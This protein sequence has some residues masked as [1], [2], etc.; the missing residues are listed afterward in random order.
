V[1]IQPTIPPPAA[2][3]RPVRTKRRT[4]ALALIVATASLAISLLLLLLADVAVHLLAAPRSGVN[5]WGY[6]GDAV[7]GKEHGERRIVA[8]GGS[9]TF[10]YGVRSGEAYPALLERSLRRMARPGARATVVNLGMNSQGAYGFRFTLEDYQY[11]DYDLVV[12][13]EGYNDLGSSNRYVA[14]RES[15]IFRLV[16]Y[17]PL[18]P[19]VVQERA[20][21]LRAAGS[22][23]AAYEGRTV[24][25]PGL[26][27][28]GA[29]AVLETG[30]AVSN[31]LNDQLARFASMPQTGAGAG[32][33]AG[34]PCGPRWAFYC[35]SVHEAV[36]W[37]LAHGKK[38]LVA[39]QP[40]LRDE[41][42]QQQAELR[43][44]LSEFAGNPNVA[45]A[46]L[47]TAIDVSN[48]AI[49]YDGMHLTGE[50]N[51]VIAERMAAHV[52]ALLP[53]A[54]AAPESLDPGEGAR[55]TVP[56]PPPSSRP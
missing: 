25:Q 41:H 42:R 38:V 54:F 23:D 7:G 26:A 46:D 53:D 34:H 40:Y 50:G 32:P 19:M 20:R 49:A 4:A 13:Y 22:L 56:S 48:R 8:I 17:F 16:G 21:A 44:M 11:L 33:V 28:R 45:Y 5:I 27:R 9:T 36:V 29:A 18:L 1:T 2:G 30:V 10:G 37:A 15:T 31:A 52:A 3:N 35:A 39:T 55:E 6:R 24:F 51:S 12:L 47:G 14:R 43:V